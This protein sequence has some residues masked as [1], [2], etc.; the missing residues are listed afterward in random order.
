MIEMPLENG[1]LIGWFLYF[2]NNG[3]TFK[4]STMEVK[5]VD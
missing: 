4:V 3:V 5:R 1:R 2:E